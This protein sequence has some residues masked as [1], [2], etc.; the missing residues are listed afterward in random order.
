MK[1]YIPKISGMHRVQ[2]GEDYRCAGCKIPEKFRK[3]I[4]MKTQLF[5][6]ERSAFTQLVF[7]IS[8]QK[9]KNT[10]LSNLFYIWYN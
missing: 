4:T 5:Q 10:R 7:F 3:T 6:Q 1:L 2:A 9:E 8:F